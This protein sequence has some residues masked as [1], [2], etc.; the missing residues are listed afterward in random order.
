M[1]IGI[2]VDIV[3]IERV[4]RILEKFSDRFLKKVF[5]AHEMAYC[6]RYRDPYPRYAAR[7]AAKEAVFKALGT[8]LAQG[9]KWLEVEIVNSPGGM[10][11]VVL[12]GKTAALAKEKGT[13]KILLSLTHDKV[14][15]VAF[16]FLG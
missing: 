14:E 10:P 2:G 9:V 5:T 3:E 7:F 13:Q 8:G 4:R 6:L 12:S 11:Q 15:A 16:V 1:V